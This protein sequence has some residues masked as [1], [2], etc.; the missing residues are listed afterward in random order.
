MK[1]TRSVNAIAVA[2]ALGLGPMAFAEEPV[3]APSRLGGNLKTFL[4]GTFP[5]QVTGAPE[6]KLHSYQWFNSFRLNGSWSPVPKLNFEAGY[7]LQ[8]VWRSSSASSASVSALPL[9]R[10]ATYRL[11]DLTT[12]ITDN[13]NAILYQN[14][15]RLNARWALASG[16][17]TVGRQAI[18]FGSA[19]V[20]QTT[21]VLLP[22]SFSQVS[23]EYRIGVDAV[24]F[25]LPLSQ[26]AELDLG[27]V[28]GEGAQ[29][30]ESAAF[31]RVQLN[32]FET[33]FVLQAM[34][35]SGARLFGGGVQT[36]LLELGYGLDFAFVEAGGRSAQDYFRLSTGLDYKFES[37]VMAFLE[38]HFN[39]AGVGAAALYAGT[40]RRFSHTRGGVFLVGRHYLIPGVTWQLT[41][42]LGAR[43]QA[44]VNAG[45][46][47]VFLSP[48]LSYSVSEAVV[49]DLGGYLTAGA[50]P[51]VGPFAW[52]TLKSEF[53]AYPALAYASLS[54]YF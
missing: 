49:L 38:Y 47:S 45:D 3:E 36:G 1:T 35:F 29:A 21:D 10:G 5:K 26:L 53:G 9:S 27:L 40:A 50:G 43:A 51:S 41:P 48:A 20:I 52:P 2:L 14:L 16:D 22:F 25:Q 11:V 12:R 13:G 23:V 18:T 54:L 42:L 15:D 37:D 30:R 46:N 8:P 33:D 17:L 32:L 44:L 34:S 7:E 6:A 24:R 31:A 4:M 28:I 19:H 39:G